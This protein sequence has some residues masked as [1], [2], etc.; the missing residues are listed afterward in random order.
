MIAAPSAL[1]FRMTAN[2]RAFSRAER[3]EVGSSKMRMLGLLASAR[4]L[5]HLAVA[6]AELLD[7]VLWTEPAP[8]SVEER[9]RAGSDGGGVDEPGAPRKIFDQHVLRHRHRREQRELLMDESNAVGARVAGRSNA[10]H[11]AR[12]T[13]LSSLGC[14]DSSE[15]VHERALTRAIGAHERVRFARLNGKM[16]IFECADAGEGL[17]DAGHLESGANHREALPEM[18]SIQMNRMI[19]IPFTTRFMK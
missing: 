9:L 2:S 4:D 14:D 3:D 11:A 7:R 5:D 6:H 12:D 8:E 10:R 13:N 15:N 19:A 17:R 1:S 18:G 16:S